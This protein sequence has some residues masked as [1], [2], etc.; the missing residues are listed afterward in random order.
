MSRSVASRS[1]TVT[2]SQ[3]EGAALEYRIQLGLSRTRTTLSQW[4]KS[5]G[6]H[7]DGVE[8]IQCM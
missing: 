6:G 2:V 1:G 4:N 3:I 5:S 7:Q 8:G